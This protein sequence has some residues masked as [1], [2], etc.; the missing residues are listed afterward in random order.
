MR[1]LIDAI[2]SLWDALL[3]GSGRGDG[4]VVD[5]ATAAKRRVAKPLAA[6]LPP[7]PV[8]A[9]HSIDIA[10][11]ELYDKRRRK[12]L[13]LRITYPA[14][15]SHAFPVIGFS[16]GAGGSHADYALLV[17]HWAA[18]GYVCLQPSHAD[19]TLPGEAPN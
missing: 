11:I 17:Q 12:V 19:A 13:P 9:G 14:R 6:R 7:G 3:P 8:G 10:E 2:R 1:A 4:V 16:H 5:A 18:H 15:A